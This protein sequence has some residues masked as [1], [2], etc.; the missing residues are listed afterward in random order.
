MAKAIISQVAYD[1]IALRSGSMDVRE[2]AP[3]LLAVGDLLQ[4]S[5][6]VLNGDRASLSVKV[7][8]DFER[9][10]FQIVFELAQSL[11]SQAHMFVT[12]EHLKTAKQ[13]A[14]LAGLLGGGA[15]GVL[16]LIKMLKGNRPTSA[17]TLQNG[18]ISLTINGSNNHVE[19]KPEVFQLANDIHIQ[20]AASCIMKPLASEGIEKFEVRRGK[21][22]METFTRDDLPAFRPVPQTERAIHNVDNER[23]VALEIIKPSFEDNLTWLF[24][25][26][27]EGRI[28]AIVRDQNFL[29]R[30]ERREIS[31]SKGDILRLKLQ[32]RTYVTAEGLRT[33]HDVIEVL[34]VIGQPKPTSL[35]PPIDLDASILSAHKGRR[36]KVRR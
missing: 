8:S 3:A 33:E 20:K 14:E 5:N 32:T 21:E 22:I 26:G 12:G 36:K 24:S 16:K 34:D 1:G 27:N 7:R 9:G 29:Q 35:L 25:D 10:S 30:L 15:I 19:I 17:T 2:L 31:F 23:I 6:R 18:N 11:A 13:I 4:H 28:G